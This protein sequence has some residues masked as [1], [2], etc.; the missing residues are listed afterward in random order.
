MKRLTSKIK[1]ASGFDHLFHIGLS[2]VL[3][4]L[5]FVLVRIDLGGLAVAVILLGKWRMFSVKPR[6]WPANIR[7]NSIDIIVGLSILIFMNNTD[8]QT[9]QL[10]WTVL[11]GSWLVFLK[12][13]NSQIAVASQAII[14]QAVGLSA[15]FLNWGGDALYLL[16]IGSWV[17]CYAASRHFFTG[18]DEPLTDFMSH[19]WGFFGASLVWVLG[20][21]LLFYGVLSQ[22]TLLLTLLG[23]G[24]AS[25]YYLEKTD[26]LSKLMRRQV[27]FIILAFVIV[28]L[29]FSNWG[30]K[31]V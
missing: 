31:A 7:A 13:Q 16:V 4:L 29:A 22:P 14:G 21:W 26:R 1:P 5:V 8:S 28:I 2:I 30:D 9:I 10:I 19:V 6:H 12:P 18:F 11:Y 23:F 27:I 25:L 20:H 17:V 15:L 3:A 24:L